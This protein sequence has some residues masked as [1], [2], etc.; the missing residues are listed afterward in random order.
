MCLL[1]VGRLDD[2]MTLTGLLFTALVAAVAAAVFGVLAR[3]G[4][5]ECALCGWRLR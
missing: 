4:G 5:G 2:L 3:H 1:T